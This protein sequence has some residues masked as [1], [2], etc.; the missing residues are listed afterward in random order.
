MEVPGPGTYAPQINFKQS[1]SY[2]LQGKYKIGTQLVLN[3][4]GGH[5]KVTAGSDFD[6]PGPGTYTTASLLVTNYASKFGT[7]RRLSDGKNK[8]QPAP[9]AYNCENSSLTVLNKSPAYG[10]GSAKRPFSE[11]TRQVPGPGTYAYK[12][13]IG[14]ES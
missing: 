5:E 2:S 1:A 8:N 9:N 13:I 14:S 6:V 4:D 11:D 10:F 3:A 12:N 7:E